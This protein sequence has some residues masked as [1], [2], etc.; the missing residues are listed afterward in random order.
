VGGETEDRIENR[1]GELANGDLEGSREN[2]MGSSND[3]KMRGIK[4]EI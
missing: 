3:E 2:G 1:V 4:R